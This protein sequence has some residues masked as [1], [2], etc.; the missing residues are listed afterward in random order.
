[1]KKLRMKDVEMDDKMIEILV[2]LSIE[3]KDIRWKR[4]FMEQVTEMLEEK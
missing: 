2:K 1:M 3:A 4:Y